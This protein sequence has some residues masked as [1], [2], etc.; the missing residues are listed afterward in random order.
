METVYY[1]LL[2]A[3]LFIAIQLK[4]EKDLKDKDPNEAKIPWST[5]LN[6]NWDDFIFAFICA[7]IL[8]Y[9]QEEVFAAL[10][11][12][13]EWN[14][15]KAWNIYYDTEYFISIGLGVFGTLIIQQSYKLGMTIIKKLSSK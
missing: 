7:L 3:F 14:A 8:G 10:M 11:H 4:I 6:K 9:V 1:A 5:F 2:G 12:W 13:Q 15:D